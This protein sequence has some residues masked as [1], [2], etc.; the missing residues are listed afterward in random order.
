MKATQDPHCKHVLFAAWRH[1]VYLH[2]LRNASPKVTIV[3]SGAFGPGAAIIALPCKFL[4][5]PQLFA[6]PSGEDRFTK[7]N[8][9][10]EVAQNLGLTVAKQAFADVSLASWFSNVNTNRDLGESPCRPQD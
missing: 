6:T 5:L 2:V 1:P 3:E 10:P 8:P 9:D 7:D 4:Q